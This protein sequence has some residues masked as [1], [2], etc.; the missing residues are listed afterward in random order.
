MKPHEPADRDLI[1]ELLADLRD[2]FHVFL[3]AD[4]GIQSRLKGRMAAAAK[5]T[6]PAVISGTGQTGFSVTTAAD[7]TVPPMTMK[8]ANKAGCKFLMG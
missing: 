5:T 8:L 1:A 4:F 2:V 6:T 7:H 3:H